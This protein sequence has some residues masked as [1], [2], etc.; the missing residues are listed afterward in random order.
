MKTRV[1]LKYFVHDC[2]LRIS[3]LNR[4]QCVNDE[5]LKITGMYLIFVYFVKLLSNLE[6]WKFY[7][8]KS[9]PRLFSTIARYHCKNSDWEGIYMRP[10]MKVCFAVRKILFRIVFIAE[11]MKWNSALFWSFYLLSLFWSNNS[12]RRCFIFGCLHNTYHPT[13]NFI[14]VKIT[15]RKEQLLW[16]S[17]QLI[18][19]KSL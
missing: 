16:F 17:F 10:E 19:Y 7:R 6:S 1:C 3:W 14:S 18:S 8:K 5:C 12:M 11:E 13:W 15:A 4:I 2:R 9:K